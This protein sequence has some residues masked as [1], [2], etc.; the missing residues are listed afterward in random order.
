[1]NTKLLAS[2]AIFALLAGVI[3]TSAMQSAYAADYGTSDKAA[4]AKKLADKKAADAKKLADKKAA[5]AK[6]LADKKAADAKKLADKK[7]ADAKKLAD[8]KAADAKKD[9]GTGKATGKASSDAVTVEMEKGTATNTECG[10]KCF[11]PNNVQVKVGGT[12]TWKNA[13][14]AAHTATDSN[15]AFDSGMVMAKGSFKHKFDTAGT[16]NYLCI[17]HPWMKGTVTAS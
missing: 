5:D 12:V 3:S 9:S 4:D 10:D 16:Y 13:D 2:I 8:K 17:V 6:K 7:A 14:T 11:V 1:M 15:G